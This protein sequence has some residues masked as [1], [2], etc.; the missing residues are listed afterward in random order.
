MFVWPTDSD[1]QNSVTS[2]EKPEPQ[3]TEV[4]PKQADPN[5]GETASDF[6]I[7]SMSK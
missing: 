1:D 3:E 7:L 2:P 6:L 4:Q 5:R